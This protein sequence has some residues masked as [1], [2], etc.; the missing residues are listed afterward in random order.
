MAEKYII[1]QGAVCLC[2]FGTSPDN[3]K[4]LSQKREY[5]NDKEGS[6]KLIGNTKDIGSTF[7][8]NTFGSCA[9]QNNKPCT[10]VVTEWKGFYEKA[11]LTN[12]GK[13]LLED[14]KGTCPIGGA[15][16]IKFIKHGQSTEV[17]KGQTSKSNSK[18]Q[19]ALNPAVDPKSYQQPKFSAE[20]ITL[21]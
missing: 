12:G 6:T 3:F 17:S 14:S 5:A 1:V 13:V 15:D 18:V 11:T 7:E 10:T 19:K 8:K 20:G 4:V 2:N 9:K 21:A 16:C